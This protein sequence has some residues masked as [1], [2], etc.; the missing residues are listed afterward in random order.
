MDFSTFVC[1]QKGYQLKIKDRM[2]SS[3]DPDEMAHY[4]PSHQGLHC[5][6]NHQF[7]STGLERFCYSLTF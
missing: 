7:C 5:L 4:E 3:V 6:Q 2:S 1:V